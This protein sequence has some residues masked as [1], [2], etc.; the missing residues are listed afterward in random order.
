MASF[1]HNSNSDGLTD[2]NIT[3][4]VD[5]FLVLLIIVM[6]SAQLLDRKALDVKI[7]QTQQE[8]SA[9]N[10][11]VEIL[12]L[13]L[14]EKNQFWLNDQL[15]AENELENTLKRVA[16]IHTNSP[17]LVSVGQEQPYKKLI[18]LLEKAKKAGF[19]KA[20]LQLE[21]QGS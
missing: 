3:P 4:L 19:K 11:K 8:L 2:I 16:Q 18:E 6:V 14:D 15:I 10:S 7:P 13:S 21:K 9:L 12:E 17:L 20:S 1:D 5:V